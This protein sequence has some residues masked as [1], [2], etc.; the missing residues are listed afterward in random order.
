MWLST[1]GCRSSVKEKFVALSRL[2]Q[3][4]I[5]VFGFH[6]SL[7][8]ILCVHHFV[9]KDRP[10]T[11]MVVRTVQAAPRIQAQAAIGAAPQSINMKKS[12]QKPVS[13]PPK[14][15]IKEKALVISKP[16]EASTAK[17]SPPVERL[18]A[19][20]NIHAI[21]PS[22]VTQMVSQLAAFEEESASST[23][24]SKP[25]SLIVPKNLPET[26]F[27]EECEI[28]YGEKIV[29]FLQ[30]SLDLPEFGEVKVDLELNASGRII[31]AEIIEAKSKKNG[32]FLKKRL[33]ELDLPCFNGDKKS[34]AILKYTITFKNLEPSPSCSF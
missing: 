4:V 30:N 31:R 7:I 29:G 11:K 22:L 19:S 18:K 1:N 34:N 33:L 6:L 12:E 15:E 26:S 21:D 9:G 2:S 20:P 32:E 28:S 13:S 8:F 10:K 17:V 3:I 16:K 14:K 23:A 5:V 27:V 25:P 24:L